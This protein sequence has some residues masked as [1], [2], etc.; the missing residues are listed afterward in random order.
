MKNIVLTGGPCAGKTTALAELKECLEERGYKVFIVEESATELINNGIRPFGENAI[1]LYEFQKIIMRY[2]LSKEATIRRKA[3]LYKNSVI[4]YDRGA[5]DN[6]SYLDELSWQ[7]LL[8]DLKLKESNL[9]NRYDMVIHLVSVAEGRE[10]LYTLDN[11]NARSEGIDLAKERDTNTLS[12]Y[13]GHHN[14]RV[15]DNSTNFEEKITRVKNCILSQLNEELCFNNQYKFLIDLSKSNLDKIKG[16]A[17]KSYIVQTYLKSDD[18]FERRVRVKMINGEV[19]YYLTIKRKIDNKEEIKTNKV[20]SKMEYLYY[21]SRRDNSINQL[22]KIRYSFKIDKE[23]YNL[24]V[25]Q[26]TNWAIL[27][28]ETT[29]DISNLKLPEFLE[30]VS[31]ED[32]DIS[33]NNKNIAKRKVLSNI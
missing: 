25:F 17:V 24:D 4:L 30:I 16:S 15:V 8:R 11:N 9:M 27:E 19:S 2:Q 14:L 6:K 3:R 32:K 10:D 18:D 29:R 26:D 21:L 13:I 5:I 12:A 23:V 20:I 33:L 28:N 1:P 31:I 22:D 7:R